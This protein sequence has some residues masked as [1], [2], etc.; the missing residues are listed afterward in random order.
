MNLKN[1]RQQKKLTQDELAKELNI[2]RPTYANYESEITQPTIETL[3]KLAD[4]FNVSIDYLVGRNYRNDLGY[5]TQEQKTLV[6]MIQELNE[7]NLIKAT[8]YI[9]G[10][11]AGQ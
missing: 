2:T 6:Q 10:L 8:S 11:V 5:L 3:I 1:L 4:Y 9:A 7:I